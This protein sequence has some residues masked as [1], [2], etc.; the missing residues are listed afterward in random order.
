MVEIEFRDSS[1]V[2]L[3]DH[4]GD[5]TSIAR[6]AWVSSKGAD[7]REQDMERIGGLINMLARD[8]HGSPF[9][10]CVVTYLVETPIFVAR[11]F[12]RHRI[13]SYNEW[14]GRY[15]IMKPVFYLPNQHRP[16]VQKGKPG[17]YTFS[18]GTPGQHGTT[19]VSQGGA[20][21][22]SWAEYEHMLDSGIAREVARN[23]LPLALF[24]S[25]YVTMN[26]RGLFNFFSLRA[27]DEEHTTVPTH[28]L[29]EIEEVAK[30]MEAHVENL[31]PIAYGAF[32]KNGRVSP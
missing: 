15:S 26:L 13:A 12:M 4:M 14:S 21:A 2:E 8:R 16:L 20:Y 18:A 25:F 10:H 7:A 9:E 30:M 5:D 17:N 22:A 23:V 1:S 28:P 11:E 24:T 27:R 31:F 29:H 19:M 3:I 6:A 32:Q